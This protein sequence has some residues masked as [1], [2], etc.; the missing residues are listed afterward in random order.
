MRKAIRY[1]RYSSDGQS[2]HSIERQDM[3]TASWTGHQQVTVT[4]TFI[5]EGYSAR[6]FDRP[7]MKALM[8]FIK[9]NYRSIDYLVVAEL[10]RFSREAGDAINMV[11]EIQ[12]TYGIRIVSAGRSCIYD[13]YDSNSFFMMG[14]EFLLGNSENIKRQNEINSGIYTAK[15]EKGK[16]IQGG[17]APFGFRKEG[18]G[19]ERRLVINEAQAIIVRHI[20]EAF[21]NNTPA[22]LIT[23]QA[24]EMGMNRTSNSYVQEILRN[25]LYMGYQHVKAWKNNPGGLYLLKDFTPII[26]A[27]MWHRV[28]EKFRPRPRVTVADDYPL[29]GVVKCWCGKC[30]TGAAS[31][32]GSG[33]YIGYYKCQVS[34]HNTINAAKAHTQLS[35]M[36]G[37]MS[38]P[39]RIV[40]AVKQ[41][42]L[43]LM[44]EKL[45]ENKVLVTAKKAE[46]E[47]TENMLH[48]VEQKFINNQL[49][50]ESY[51]RWHR[52]LREKRMVLQSS[53]TK[54]QQGEEQVYFLL[55]NNLHKLTDLKS[56]YTVSTTVQKQELLRQLFD[57][58]LYYQNS[59][60]RTPYIMPVF[61][62]N[63]LLL[64][65]KQLLFIDN[66]SQRAG[67]VEASSLLSNSFIEF[68]TLLESMKVA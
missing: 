26:S 51:D 40:T 16:W 37:Y 9:K 38:L 31:R 8:L 24:N 45:K 54:M 7:D 63:T 59:S 6:T 4:D 68:L 52:E 34:G 10:T 21:L 44:D 65:Q 15:T 33:K 48:S 11:K 1:L 47:T 5:D 29:R 3:I 17:K 62:H 58:R 60:Y 35:D 61:S 22:Y 53:I 30:L 19:K 25:P 32:N 36:L 57:N 18:V 28:Q 66:N 46:L 56:I 42:A 20:Y 49:Q 41:K 50:F 2:Q 23:R 55:N 43:S 12:R 14:L 13:V 27:D 64:N 67:E 39:Q